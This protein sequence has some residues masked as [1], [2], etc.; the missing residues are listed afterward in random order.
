MNY[1]KRVELQAS[2]DRHRCLGTFRYD[3]EDAY[4]AVL[5]LFS[6]LSANAEDIV[7]DNYGHQIGY[8]EHQ[9]QWYW[10]IAPDGR[11]P[12]YVNSAGWLFAGV[13]ASAWTGQVDAYGNGFVTLMVIPNPDGTGGGSYTWNIV[14]G[15]YVT[16]QPVRPDIPRPGPVSPAE[17]LAAL[18]AQLNA[19]WKTMIPLAQQVMRPYEK[20]WIRRK[21]SIADPSACA[22][23]VQNRIAY[24]QQWAKG[25]I[26]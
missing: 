26:K 7:Y 17:Q 3:Y 2:D 8:V 24:L 6:A 21:D 16:P 23:E 22:T 20:N 5:L 9:N 25:K 12:L 10:D 1:N 4:I 15:R 18:E 19:V 14:G 11:T 13:M